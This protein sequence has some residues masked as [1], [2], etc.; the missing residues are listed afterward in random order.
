MAKREIA[1]SGTSIDDL[2]REVEIVG[3][4]APDV[5]KQAMLAQVQVGKRVTRENWSTMGWGKHG[6]LVY[7][8]ISCKSEFSSVDPDVVY[9]SYGVYSTDSIASAHGKTDRDMTAAQLAWWAEFGTKQL[10]PVAFLTSAHLRSIAE[11]ET[12]FSVTFNRII[13]GRISNG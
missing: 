7:D 11:Q 9:G 4:F 5:I 10:A 6:D 2:I 1:V 13:D 8:S 3:S 12:A